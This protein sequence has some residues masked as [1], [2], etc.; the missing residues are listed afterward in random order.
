MKTKNKTSKKI[1]R[2]ATALMLLFI[3][4]FSLSSY[5]KN[6][7]TL[8]QSKTFVLVHGAFQ[9]PYAWYSVK[10]QLEKAGQK[11]V[12][13]ELPGHGQD[14]TSPSAINM[15]LYRDKVISE[16]SKIKG[17]VILV[18]HSMGG[19]IITAVADKIPERIEKLVYLA[20]FIPANGQALIDYASKD[21]DSQLNPALSPSADH[22]TV[23][24]AKEKLFSIFCQDGAP[25]IE[26][27][28][29]SNNR[30]EPAAPFYD[31]ITLNASVF[32]SMQKYYIYTVLDKALSYKIQQQMV[33]VA[34]ITKIY[35]LNSSHCP[36]LSVPDKVTSILLEITK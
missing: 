3:G 15:N 25:A 12:V 17:K 31:K 4:L 11:V 2:F 10:E 26:Q 20:A 19:V 8:K 7:N 33:N 9:G 13:V 34:G 1:N 30:A 28:L 32:N 14:Q 23:S 27:V 16:I 36:H 6:Y 22:T 24:V 18:G 5:S 21:A 35:T 29:M